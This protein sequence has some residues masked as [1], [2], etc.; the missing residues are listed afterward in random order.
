MII[1]WLYILV[2]F[3]KF[4]SHSPNRHKQHAKCYFFLLP[5]AHNFQQWILWRLFV[6]DSWQHTIETTFEFSLNPET[7]LVFLYLMTMLIHTS[8]SPQCYSAV[9]PMNSLSISIFGLDLNTGKVKVLR[10]SKNGTIV[11]SRLLDFF[12]GPYVMEKTV[13]TVTSL[14][15]FLNFWP[16][17]NTTS[18]TWIERS[19]GWLFWLPKIF[20]SSHRKQA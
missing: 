3:F 18:T 11:I 2:Y 9:M 10:D 1:Y 17:L 16:G 13:Q 6:P 5:C 4:A 20:Q 7:I 12:Y 19:G 14:T 8:T 15:L